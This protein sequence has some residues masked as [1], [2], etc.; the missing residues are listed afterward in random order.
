VKKV[1][2]REKKLIQKRE[3]GKK[4][5]PSEK[6]GSAS[7]FSI[8][9]F[10]QFLNRK[11][12]FYRKIDLTRMPRAYRHLQPYL[13]PI[14]PVIHIIGTNGKGT[15]GRFLAWGLWELER[16]RRGGVIKE[17]WEGIEKVGEKKEKN[18]GISPKT[19]SPKLSLIGHYTSP[20]LFRF[21]ERIWVDG[22]PVSDETLEKVHREI[23]PQL[24][25][26]LAEELS[27]FEYTTLIAGG[28][29]RNVKIPIVE[30]GL[31]GEW[32]ATFQFPQEVSLVTPI[33][34]DHQA[35]LGDSIG[36]IATTKLRGVKREAIV[37]FQLHWEEVKRVLHREGV[38]YRSYREFFT[39]K[40][41]EEYRK[42]FTLP[43]FLF[44]NLLLA[45]AYF[46]WKGLP[47]PST[48]FWEKLDLRGR[49]EEVAP[50]IWVDVGHNPL[51]ARAIKE[52]FQKRGIQVDLLYNS[53]RDKNVEEILQILKPV[54][55][56]VALL[57]VPDNPRIFPQPELEKL[58]RKLDIPLV[59]PSQ[60]TKP[61]LVWGSFS[62]VERFLRSPLF[63]SFKSD[64][65]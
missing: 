53:Y 40:E 63:S 5:K 24:P 20:H 34:L 19:H 26:E 10:F 64:R 30:A 33:D 35:F 36:K 50:Q 65:N 49:L 47:A 39:G 21:N 51:G 55:K 29:F 56:R 31:G 48:N 14:N 45:L 57:P 38:K 17:N 25:R 8:P 4:G 62:V 42:R 28:V 41:I 54:I 37:G 43:E 11:P 2:K 3:S 22:E 46:R 12:L 59:F 61:L 23:Y 52:Y 13:E 18:S 7:S 16:E 58:L 27:Y 1:G 44:P 6:E 9:P 15:T 60:L 32:D